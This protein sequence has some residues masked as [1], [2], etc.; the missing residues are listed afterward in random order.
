M[1]IVME[2]I[3]HLSHRI[4]TCGDWYYDDEGTL[5]IRAS[6]LSNEKYEVIL[7]VHELIEAL[8]CRYDG[9]PVEEVDAFDLEFEHKIANRQTDGGDEPGDEP[10][11]P[12]S[13]QH[14]LATAFERILAERWGIKWKTYNAELYELPYPNPWPNK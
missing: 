6:K 3:D 10:D 9:V 12:Y 8:A 2:S 7:L 1:K 14:C 11:A 5:H 4:P 13:D